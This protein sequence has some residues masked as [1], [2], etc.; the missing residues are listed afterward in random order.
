MDKFVVRS[1]RKNED[2]DDLRASLELESKAVAAVDNVNR[3]NRVE[4]QPV[5]NQDCKI[6][7]S[8]N[9]PAVGK[10]TVPSKF[11]TW[12]KENPWLEL[13]VN[14]CTV[15]LI[16]CTE[17]CERKLIINLDSRSISSKQ[18]WVDDGFSNWKHGLERIKAHV[19][20]NLHR[21][22]SEAL[23]NVKE[24]NVAELVSTYHLKQMIENRMAL[25]KIF[26]TL[27]VLAKQG[28][29][30]RGDNND[31]KSNFMAFLN[32]RA[33]DVTELQSW[34]QRGGHKWLHHETQNEILNLMANAI[35]SEIMKE[36]REAE[37]FSILLDETSDI[38]RT[39]EVSVCIRIFFD[40][41]TSKEYFIGFFSIKDIKA[42][43]LFDLVNE[44]LVSHSLSLLKLRGQCY[45]GDA[46]VSGNISGL[47]T[48]IREEEPRALFV[49]FTAHRMSLC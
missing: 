33:E 14:N 9:Q 26:C 2:V 27:R 3:V 44:I 23:S 24:I 1:K 40:N 25:R 12:K 35:L 34:L 45:D 4:N 42:K 20:S 43:T 48:R 8:E 11:K 47:Q 32:A 29:P 5:Q 41:L 37:F 31:E 22:S 49:H 17:A 13:N 18:A 15:L 46:N 39:E 7:Y 28:L 21:D 36:I 30:T 19:K 16:I 6:N 38:S 10:S